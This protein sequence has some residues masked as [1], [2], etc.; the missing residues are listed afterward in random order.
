MLVSR[1]SHQKYLQSV[2]TRFLEENA[3]LNDGGSVSNPRKFDLSEFCSL[4]AKYGFGEACD[5]TRA[6]IHRRTDAANSSHLFYPLDSF[7]P[8]DTPQ[9][10]ATRK[11]CAKCDVKVACLHFAVEEGLPNNI[12]GGLNHAERAPLEERFQELFGPDAPAIVDDLDLAERESQ[13]WSLLQ[14]QVSDESL[15]K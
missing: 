12:Y 8:W 13:F 11:R 15:A 6:R 4:R 3:C 1:N 7:T 5:I 2:V 14:A 10:K 9:D